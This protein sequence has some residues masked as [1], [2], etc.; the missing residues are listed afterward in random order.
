MTQASP[1]KRPGRSATKKA[2]RPYQRHIVEPDLTPEVEK[3]IVDY[4]VA[5]GDLETASVGS[6]VPK[7]V[8]LSWMR[9]GARGEE[10]F[11]S[12]A[13][14]MLEAQA[15][16]ELRKALSVE[17]MARDEKVPASIRFQARTW[18][19]PITAP[20]ASTPREPLAATTALVRSGFGRPSR[21]GELVPLG[22]DGEMIPN[23]DAIANAIRLGVPLKYASGLCALNHATVLEWIARGVEDVQAGKTSVHVD[24]ATLVAQARGEFVAQNVRNVSD[25]G[26]SDWRAS[27]FLL[28]RRAPDE[29]AE[30][31]QVEVGVE[32]RKELPE[33]AV[34]RAILHAADRFRDPVAIEA[35]CT[36]SNG[37]GNGSR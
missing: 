4:V 26:S 33:D 6:G 32:L 14:H 20:S 25:A 37:S 19:R 31:Q 35:D 27:A 3:S 7:S 34:R 2:A 15:K 22:P 5:I 8:L 1:A 29:F 30:R 9:R 23:T 36:P 12:F 11:A 24:F 16:Y 17:E 18:R 10:P 21:I 13:R 28:E